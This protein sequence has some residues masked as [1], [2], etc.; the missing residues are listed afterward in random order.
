MTIEGFI[1][2]T[3]RHKKWIVCCS[4][5]QKKPVIS[6]HL[7]EIDKNCHLNMISC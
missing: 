5:E 2:A 7:Q 1:K 3:K 4:Y 6:K